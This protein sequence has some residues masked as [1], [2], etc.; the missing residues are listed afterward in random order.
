[1]VVDTHSLFILGCIFLL[2]TICGFYLAY[3]YGHKT[4][5]FRWSEYFL[6]IIWPAMFVVALA[7]LVDLKVIELFIF[8]CII[9]FA[10][11]YAVGF[12]Y[13][14]VLN[15]RLWVYKKFSLNGYTSWLVLPIWGIAGVIF[16]YLGAVIGL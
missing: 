9:G 3:L 14:Q 8:S 6:I 5:K 10:L 12:I 4:K 2:L 7:Y 1:M 16:W 15:R 13:H 11:E